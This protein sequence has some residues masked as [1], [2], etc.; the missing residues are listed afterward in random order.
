MRLIKN[1]IQEKK[2]KKKMSPDENPCWKGYE[3]IGT[4]IKDGKEVPNCV[5]ISKESVKLYLSKDLLDSK[6]PMKEYNDSIYTLHINEKESSDSY[7]HKHESDKIIYSNSKILPDILNYL[8][9]YLDTNNIEFKNIK[10]I[11]DLN[12]QITTD[13]PSIEVI[14]EKE[15][16]AWRDFEIG[17]IYAEFE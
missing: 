14:L 10:K 11:N 12:I 9:S 1:L 6:K 15:I 8:S 17:E 16:S 3:M 4:K 5:P 13:N 2:K 7:E